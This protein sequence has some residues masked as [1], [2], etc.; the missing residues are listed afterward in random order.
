MCGI[1]VSWRG[2]PYSSQW[3]EAKGE[4]LLVQTAA[5]E[6]NLKLARI[7]ATAK[8][9]A[10]PDEGAATPTPFVIGVVSPDPFQGGLEKLAVRKI[11]D[12]TIQ[13]VVIRSEKDYVDCHVLFVPAAA[14]QGLVDDLI[15]LTLDRPVLVWRDRSDGGPGTGVACTF[16]REEES[17]LIET[18]PAELKRR[19]L[20][21]DGRLLSLNLIR[22]VKPRK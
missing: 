11:K 4:T 5:S 19:G 10:W 8:F 22:I 2:Q 7:Y 16:V 15:K 21:P 18:D 6:Y 13:T 20:V 3:G 1:A 17:L 12:R 9:I 14:D